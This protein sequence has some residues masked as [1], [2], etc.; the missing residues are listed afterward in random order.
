MLLYP[1]VHQPLPRLQYQ[2]GLHR[3]TA[4]GIDLTQD[5]RIIHQRLLDIVASA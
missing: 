1:E 2:H 3:L 5:W 4:T